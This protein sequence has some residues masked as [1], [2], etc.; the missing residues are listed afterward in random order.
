MIQLDN[1]CYGT[2]SEM[3]ALAEKRVSQCMPIIKIRDGALPPAAHGLISVGSR[4][5]PRFFKALC[6]PAYWELEVLSKLP[7]L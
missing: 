3:V 7:R 2:F 4:G 6:H 5:V 1:I